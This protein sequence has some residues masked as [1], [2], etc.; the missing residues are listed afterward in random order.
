MLGL[1]GGCAQATEGGVTAGVW[2]LTV[3]G[4]GWTAGEAKG[5]VP[6]VRARKRTNEAKMLAHMDPSDQPCPQQVHLRRVQLM[7]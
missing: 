4:V 2:P 3:K 5:E 6:A 1:W 7:C